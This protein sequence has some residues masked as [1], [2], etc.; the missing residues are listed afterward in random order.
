MSG[1]A[2]SLVAN[3]FSPAGARA[4]PDALLRLK[5]EVG[6][7][8]G[9]GLGSFVE[10]IDVEEEI[11]FGDIPGVPVSGVEGHAG[12][13]VIG[14]IAGVRVAVAQGRVH[15]YEGYSAAEV[16]AGVRVLAAMGVK[17]LVLTNAAGAL[18]PDFRPGV[19]MQIVDHLNLQGVSPLSGGPRFVDMTEVYS[20]RWRQDLAE[21][22]AEASVPLCEGVYAAVLGPQYE[23]PAEVR[24]LGSLGADAVG[25]STVSEAIQARALGLEVAGF[26]CL[27]NYGAGLRRGEPLSHEEVVEVGT[28]AAGQLVQLWTAALGRDGI[29]K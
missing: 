1:N 9:S 14:Q 5:P 21:A 27:T 2:G 17:R 22:A 3:E 29:S 4:L 18:H 12:R 8:L 19:W 6:L 28:R 25:M 16:A 7:V 20:K 10:N 23:T 13:F 15:L 26:S 24:M 11:P